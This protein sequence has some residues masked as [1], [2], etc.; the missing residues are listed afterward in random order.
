M[1]VERK[2]RMV[3]I[4]R[5]RD[6][7]LNMTN[8]A[9]NGLSRR[10]N[11]WKSAP[12][13]FRLFRTWTVSR[14][15]TRQYQFVATQKRKAHK[16]S[17]DTNKRRTDEWRQADVLRRLAYGSYKVTSATGRAKVFYQI[18]SDA[19]SV[20]ERRR[21]TKTSNDIGVVRKRES[22]NGESSGLG[23]VNLMKSTRFEVNRKPGR[24]DGED[25]AIKT[26]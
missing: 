16:F 10:P 9:T 12:S 2:E 14:E 23:R 4:R 17:N 25:A 8:V 18:F 21:W 24:E 19:D 20:Q 5:W 11:S 7:R 15:C 1:S 22:K 3:T 13:T 6:K 26:F